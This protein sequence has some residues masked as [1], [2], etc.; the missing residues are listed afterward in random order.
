MDKSTIYIVIRRFIL[1]IP[2]I[3]LVGLH[4]MQP[5]TGL[6]SLVSTHKPNTLLV[7][8]QNTPMLKNRKVRTTFTAP[9][10]FLGTI[11][12]HFNSHNRFVNDWI[13]FRLREQGS[14]VWIYQNQYNTRDIK[15]LEMF[16]FGFPL[17]HNSK[18]RTYEIELIS[19]NGTGGNSVEISAEASTLQSKYQFPR[20][21]IFSHPSTGVDF[22][23]S[24]ISNSFAEHHLLFIIALLLLAVTPECIPLNKVLLL[25]IKG[26]SVFFLFYYAVAIPHAYAVVT[27]AY[28]LFMYTLIRNNRQEGKFVLMFPLLILGIVL[29]SAIFGNTQIADKMGTL[30][31]FMSLTST[32][33]LVAK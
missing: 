32:L 3:I 13:Q 28:L 23:I 16:P 30:W 12:I 31:L 7:S 2:C 24:K 14:D 5:N 15:N 9:H 4:I 21:M 19:K 22:L 29:V 11:F 10:N 25:I 17:I 27:I 1:V 33:V 6:T 20:N 8:K 18:G 26:A